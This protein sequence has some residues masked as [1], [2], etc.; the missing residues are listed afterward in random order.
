MKNTLKVR[1]VYITDTLAI[2]KVKQ[3]I[4]IPHAYP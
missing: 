4:K 3:N 2:K 1:Y